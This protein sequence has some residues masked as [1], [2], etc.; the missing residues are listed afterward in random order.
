MGRSCSG[1]RRRDSASGCE[2]D[3]SQPRR[4]RHEQLR[5]RLGGD[6]VESRK[7]EEGERERATRCRERGQRTPSGSSE[8]SMRPQEL[9]RARVS[10]V[11]S[12]HGRHWSQQRD[13]GAKGRAP[14]ASQATSV[15][16][17]T[18]PGKEAAILGCSRTIP[19]FCCNQCMSCISKLHSGEH[20]HM[21]CLRW[22]SDDDGQSRI[23]VRSRSMRADW[24]E[25][26]A[27]EYA[28]AASDGAKP[29]SRMQMCSERSSCRGEREDAAPDRVCRSTRAD[30]NTSISPHCSNFSV[31]SEDRMAKQLDQSMAIRDEATAAATVAVSAATRTRSNVSECSDVATSAVE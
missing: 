24:R 31:C 15:H 22:L 13:V 9:Q 1:V 26:P 4:Q 7:K 2:E 6:R 18:R 21:R 20:S 28:L 23:P 17:R 29:S 8:V 19:L 12:P 30:N 5:R 27:K 3:K 14:A 10:S 25:Q 16:R 11:A